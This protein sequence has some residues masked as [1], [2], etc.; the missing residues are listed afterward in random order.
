[1]KR[2]LMLGDCLKRMKEI[3]DN[4]IDMILCDP[5]YGT[6]RCKW[7]TVI[8]FELMW[9]QVNRVIKENGAICLFA[10]NPFSA[11]LIMSN[12]KMF[13]YN[14]VWEKEA[15]TGFF[16]CKEIPIK[17]SRGYISFLQ[18]TTCL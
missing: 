7:D 5:P 13:K 17:K 3:P 18:K 16:K 10:Q 15:G 8:D 11:N 6:T 14:W 1:M 4:S 9:E 12:P 2:K